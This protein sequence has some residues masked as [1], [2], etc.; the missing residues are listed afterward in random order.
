[1]CNSNG[2]VLNPNFNMMKLHL[3][4]AFTVVPPRCRD[5]HFEEN[6]LSG[7]VPS[8]YSTLKDLR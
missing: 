6:Q 5:A 4:V 1:M 2:L 7:G 3:S 8:E